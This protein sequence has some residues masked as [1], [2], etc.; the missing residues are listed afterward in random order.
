MNLI[1]KKFEEFTLNPN[2]SIGGKWNISIVRNNGAEIFP[3]GKKMKKNM[4]LNQGLDIIASNKYFAA[5]NGFNWNTIPGFLL[6]DAVVGGNSYNTLD[7]S[8]T[9]LGNLLQVSYQTLPD[10]CVMTDNY[11][12]GSRTFSKVYDFPRGNTQGLKIREIG[13]RTPFGFSISNQNRLFSKFILPE[14]ISVGSEEWIR[15][16]YDFTI[17][18]DAIVNPIN[19]N[20]SS[21]TIN[22]SGK[23]KLCGNYHDLFGDFNTNGSPI[24][25]YGDSPQSSFM[26][27]CDEFCIQNNCQAQCVGTSYLIS[28]I[29]IPTSPGSQ[30]ICEWIGQR[31]DEND[32]TI[33]PS[34]YVN[35]NFYRDTTYIFKKQNP[36]EDKQFSAFLFTIRKSDRNNTIAG[37]LW[38]FNNKQIKLKEKEIVI[39]IRQSMSRI[40]T[41]DSIEWDR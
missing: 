7:P 13:V 35:G 31:T 22:A 39:E 4:I 37:W 9:E 41:P 24:I 12:N 29:F 32:G 17:K 28:N 38:E 30:I 18:C 10:R 21:G 5:S 25:R 27:Y 15:L 26:P 36:F 1:F 16:Y 23:L 20:L 2:I 19:I 3:F 14:D 33:I 6:G 40:D 8:D 34:S 11:T